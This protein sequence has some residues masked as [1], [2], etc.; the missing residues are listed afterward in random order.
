VW[1][2]RQDP[3][4]L[5]RQERLRLGLANRTVN[6]EVGTLKAMLT[7]AAACGLNEEPDLGFEAPAFWQGVRAWA[8]ARH[9]AQ[10]LTDTRHSSMSPGKRSCITRPG[11]FA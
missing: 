6:V 8:S 5:Y 7:W 3:V 9:P 2:V 1:E 4:L 10:D 11:S